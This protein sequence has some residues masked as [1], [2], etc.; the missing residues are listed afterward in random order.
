MIAVLLVDDH[1]VVRAGYARLLEQDGACRVVAEADSMAAGYQCFVAHEPDI[2]ITDLS[3]PDASGLELLR[4]IRARAPSARVLL[5]SIH[6]QPALAERA[7]ELGAAGYLGKRSAPQD[8]CAAVRQVARGGIWFSEAGG[9]EQNLLEGLT[10]REF[11]VFRLIAS[12]M[13]PAACAEALHL[14]AK[15]VANHQTAIKDKLGLDNA[16]ALAH[17]ALR[18]GVIAR[19]PE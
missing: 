3:L 13:S 19:P 6:D 5:F 1:P 8:L 16:A 7:R 9:S 11:E 15:T 10:P 12:G 4:R 14:S 2:T 17:L 18:C